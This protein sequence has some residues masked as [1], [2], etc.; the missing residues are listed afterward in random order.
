MVS[1]V[2]KVTMDMGTEDKQKKCF[3]WRTYAIPEAS[4]RTITCGRAGGNL[5]R[6]RGSEDWDAIITESEGKAGRL[7]LSDF[8]ASTSSASHPPPP[9]PPR[10]ASPTSPSV[11]SSLNVSPNVGNATP[12]TTIQRGQS[13]DKCPNEQERHGE[14]S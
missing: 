8:F 7:F 1:I 12:S 6:R 13:A 4:D 2:S 5:Q 11:P 14:N 9:A 3:M 10:S